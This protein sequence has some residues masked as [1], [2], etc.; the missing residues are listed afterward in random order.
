MTSFQCSIMTLTISSKSLTINSYVPRLN[1]KYLGKQYIKG[2]TMSSSGS[3]AK[4][5][6]SSS[7]VNDIVEYDEVSSYLSSN[8]ANMKLA[9]PNMIAIS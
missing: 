4:N 8:I 2:S 3:D 9:S 5:S 1:A 7:N 6:L